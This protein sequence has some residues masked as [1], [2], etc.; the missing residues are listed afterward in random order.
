MVWCVQV[1]FC[2]PTLGAGLLI[3]RA[4]LGGAVVSTLGGD[5]PLALRVGGFCSTL[6]G[7]SGLFRWD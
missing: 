2:V 1:F 5:G 3:L 6:G 7:A 4:T